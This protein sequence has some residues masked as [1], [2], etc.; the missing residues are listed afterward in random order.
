LLHRFELFGTA[1]DVATVYQG[2]T[3]C[4]IPHA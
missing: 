1:D 4:W 2:V 3:E